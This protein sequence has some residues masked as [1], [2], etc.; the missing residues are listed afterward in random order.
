MLIRAFLIRFLNLFLQAEVLEL[1]EAFKAVKLQMATELEMNAK[2][3]KE[4][5]EDLTSTKHQLLEI[6]HN[7]SMTEK[8]SELTQNCFKSKTTGSNKF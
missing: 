6:Q 7:L 2:T 5:E 4:L 1:N 3:Q 8:V